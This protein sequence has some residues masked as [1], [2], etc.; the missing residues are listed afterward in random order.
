MAIGNVAVAKAG[1]RMSVKQTGKQPAATAAH[2]DKGQVSKMIGHLKYHSK[3]DGS[4]AKKVLDAYQ[5][6]SGEGKRAILAKFH[7]PNGKKLTWVKEFMETTT[8]SDSTVVGHVM[9]WYHRSG[10]LLEGC[11]L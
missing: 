9:D 1:R 3:T 8:E 2:M 10:F 6:A 4:D 7:G 11:L 5:E